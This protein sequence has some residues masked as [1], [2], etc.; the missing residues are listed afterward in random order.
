MLV[1]DPPAYRLGGLRPDH[2]VISH[3]GG[4]MRNDPLRVG[5]RVDEPEARDIQACA[6]IRRYHAGTIGNLAA[7]T[8][9]GGEA[10]PK[11]VLAQRA[12]DASE[13]MDVAADRPAIADKRLIETLPVIQPFAADHAADLKMTP[14]LVDPGGRDPVRHR[15]WQWT[16]NSHM[17]ETGLIDLE[18][19]RD[20]CRA[21]GDV[22]D[23]VD[24][25]VGVAE[26]TRE[27]GDR[28]LEAGC[29]DRA[30]RTLIGV[31]DLRLARPA[32]GCRHAAGLGDFGI[33][34][35]VVQDAG[36]LTRQQ[37]AKRAIRL[38]QPV[39]PTAC[40][41]GG[42][43]VD[44]VGVVDRPIPFNIR[45]DLAPGGRGSGV[46]DD[47]RGAWR[48][49]E[50]RAARM[51]NRVVERDAVQVAGAT[52]PVEKGVVDLAALVIELTAVRRAV[53]KPLGVGPCDAADAQRSLGPGDQKRSRE[54]ADRHRRTRRPGLGSKTRHVWPG[55]GRGRLR[56]LSDP[57]LEELL[58]GP[59]IRQL[60][61]S[62][63]RRTRQQHTRNSQTTNCRRAGKIPLPGHRSSLSTRHPA[64]R[65]SKGAGIFLSSEYAT[66]GSDQ[67]P[68]SGLVGFCR[69]VARA[70]HS[71]LSL[72]I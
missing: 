20:T 4:R 58:I 57:F 17:A 53:D 44:G 27:I 22:R 52:V 6:E 67:A 32:G 68:S 35:G 61:G 24:I 51:R 34:V 66:T 69:S 38:A 40:Y 21:S 48:D 30:V 43:A 25:D 63:R 45:L 36:L 39:E 23:L 18:P 10:E 16:E 3:P 14:G 64:T 29:Q 71:P 37:P 19:R 47:A 9:A 33:G 54:A 65:L 1:P 8:V 13:R 62:R 41:P 42:A 2:S 31:S 59:Q 60:V 28:V 49:H 46:D 5:Q 70:Q 7:D 15:V 11:I 55:G 56:E 50:G 12:G 72:L 26:P